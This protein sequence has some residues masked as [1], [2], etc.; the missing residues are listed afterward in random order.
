[1]KKKPIILGSFLAVAFSTWLMLPRAIVPAPGQAEKQRGVCWVGGRQEV[2]AKELESIKKL[3]I[4]WISQT[5]FAW[6]E[7]PQSPLI[8]LNTGS[9]R[10][11]WGESD[12]GIKET[13]RLARAAGIKTMLKPHLWIHQSWPGDVQMESDSLWQ[14]W[15][16]QYRHFILH[17]A[18][19]AEE[20]QIEILCIGTELYHATSHEAAWRKLIQNIRAIYHGQ[21]TYAANFTQEYEE[22]KFWDALDFI[23][24]Q[25]YFPLS[26][27]S[28]P[29]VEEMVA[30]WSAPLQSLEEL[31]GRYQRPVIFTEIGYRSTA[32]AAIEPWRWPQENPGNS[33][34]N[35]TQA[36]CYEAFFQASW[37]KPWLGGA[38]FWKWYPHGS[39]RLAEIDFTPQGKP[40]QEILSRYFHAVGGN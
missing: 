11:W 33:P 17:Y 24:V 36:R 19:L 29:T 16:D 25:A 21:I 14:A 8:R 6:Q 1:M 12:Q 40:A 28:N 31:A 30:N 27:N 10:V 7:N 34:S 35:E 22:I 5:P 9:D 23:G 4:N 3:N 38:Y 37:G 20:S 13:T 15:F 26:G 32:D 2:T 18:R 39:H